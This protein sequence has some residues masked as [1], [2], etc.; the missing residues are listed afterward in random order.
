MAR[1]SDL[2]FIQPPLSSFYRD[3]K[4][5][6]IQLQNALDTLVTSLPGKVRRPVDLEKALAIDK[7][8]AWRVMT[9][10][11]S[12]ETANLA[13]NVP[14]SLA[15]QKFLAIACAKGI[16]TERVAEA[17]QALEELDA[18]V[19]RHCGNRKRFER[20]M[21]TQTEQVATDPL[22][23][24]RR[25]A[26]EANALLWGASADV[27]LRMGMIGRSHDLRGNEVIALV[28]FK[29]YIGLELLR[30]ALSW[31]LGITVT[32]QD[33]KVPQTDQQIEPLFDLQN[34]PT[35]IAG[36]FV[37]PHVHILST[38]TEEGWL[39]YS[40]QLPSV[41]KTA[42]SRCIFGNI[43]QP[44]ES[45]PTV[46]SEMQNGDWVTLAS[47][48]TTP[49]KLLIFDLLVERARYSNLQPEVLIVAESRTNRLLS[50][51]PLPLSQKVQALGA[52]TQSAP[53]L[54]VSRYR[55]MLDY[56]LRR[57]GWRAEDFDLYRLRLEYPVLSTVVMIRF[58]D[59]DAPHQGQKA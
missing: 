53:L 10:L 38:T 55:E 50:E 57:K 15:I 39:R 17:T 44:W 59:T 34:P 7:V 24:P 49:S 11:S 40:A 1:M 23:E 58:R 47:G 45:V 29:G 42:T 30:P 8:L 52:A 37:D 5:A 54:E 18:V 36:L 16:A 31:P 21:A 19:M 22:L 27:E 4:I 3:S 48:I 41:G 51:F 25:T 32:S 33:S 43:V 13:K 26:F 20:M 14:G 6:L 28:N 12:H 2:D 9:F 35:E 56:G 46:Q